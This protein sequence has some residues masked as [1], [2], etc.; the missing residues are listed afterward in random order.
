MSGGQVFSG[1]PRVRLAEG[2]PE[3]Y[4]HTCLPGPAVHTLGRL[5]RY[6]HCGGA[7]YSEEASWVSAA[8]EG[9]ER[10]YSVL[11]S[12]TAE[13]HY[14]T[15]EQWTCDALRPEEWCPFSAAQYDSP[16]FPCRP[17]TSHTA[18]KWYAGNELLTG[19]ECLLPGPLVCF[20]YRRRRGEDRIYPTTTTGLACGFGYEQACRAALWEVIERDAVVLAWHWGLPVRR[21]DCGT[22]LAR[23]LARSVGV[24]GRYEI[25][26]YDI[27]SDLGVPTCMV[28]VTARG[29]RG[30][31]LAVGS[32]CRGSLH[33]ALEKAFLEA[34]QG[35][36]YVRD[37]CRQLAGW[38]SGSFAEVTSFQHCAAFYSLFPDALDRYLQGRD[39]FLDAAE[40]VSVESRPGTATPDVATMVAALRR[41]GYAAYAVDMSPEE[42]RREGFAL[43]RVAVPGLYSLEGSYKYRSGGSARAHAAAERI[44]ARPRP[45]PFPHPLP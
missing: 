21:I 14:G 25:E 34:M 20:A 1:V 11:F 37:L 44:G 6:T 43:A 10:Y 40:V 24:D 7:G 28:F 39:G 16:E 22:G 30:R 3:I 19:R 31:L 17:L 36:P 26:A 23:D 38:T 45:N 35:V 9:L 15:W 42:A 13:H 33:T 2:D 4:C 41:L 27:T 32:A 29:G 18:L 5:A 8:A 12:L